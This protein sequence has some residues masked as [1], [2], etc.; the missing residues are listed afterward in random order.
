VF[1]ITYASTGKEEVIYS[2][3]TLGL[4]VID[5]VRPEV[6]Y[7]VPEMRHYI[8]GR[9]DWRRHKAPW[10]TVGG[11]A[12]GVAGAYLGAFYGLLVPAAYV[13]IEGLSKVRIQEEHVS[14]PNLIMNQA[15]QDGY[16]KSAR[17]KKL[18]N[19]I[20]SSTVGFGVGLGAFLLI[21]HQ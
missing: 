10:A 14:D 4:L 8:Q 2:P 20:L 13:T 11:A 15:Y 18:K 3:D 12:A 19:I 17:R 1:S 16:V 21:F 6:E 7:T 5:S 9:I